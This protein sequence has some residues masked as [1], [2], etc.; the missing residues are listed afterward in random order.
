MSRPVIGGVV[1]GVVVPLL[2]FL[3]LLG[4]AGGGLYALG[5]YL[6][7]ATAAVGVLLLVP[8]RTRPWGLGILLGFTG[9]VVAGGGV[10]TAV[11]VSTG[12]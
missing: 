9:L 10:C 11:L 1:V 5:G 6:W 3:P 2:S 12:A 8:Q 4:A 7:M